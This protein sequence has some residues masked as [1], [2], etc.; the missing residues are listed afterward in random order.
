MHPISPPKNPMKIPGV[1]LAGNGRPDPTKVMKRKFVI[2][3]S[4]KRKMNIRRFAP[5]NL[6]LIS[7]E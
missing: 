2:C 7:F 1:K 4:R 6:R 5:Q 3:E